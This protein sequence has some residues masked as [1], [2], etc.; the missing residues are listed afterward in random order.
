MRDRGKNIRE[1]ETDAL[2][3]QRHFP[4]VTAGVRVWWNVTQKDKKKR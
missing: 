4:K 2:D 3:G 1:K